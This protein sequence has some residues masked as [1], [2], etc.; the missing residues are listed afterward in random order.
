MLRWFVRY[1]F[2]VWLVVVLAGAITFGHSAP[3]P[4][5]DGFLWLIRPSIMTA[6]ILFLMAFSLDSSKRA[7]AL[8]EPLASLWGCLV[9]VGLMP[10][11][12]WPLAGVQP[13][14]D[15]NWGLFVT[16]VTPCTLA[17]ASVFTRRAGGNDAVSLLTTLITNL[18]CV[19]ITPLW[20]QMYFG[21]SGGFDGW[22]LMQQLGICVLLPT[23]FGQAA[24][25]PLQALVSRYRAWIG[26]CAQVLVL[27]LVAVAATNAGRVLG[28][29][30][31]WPTPLSAIAMAGSCVALHLVAV[32]IGWY[33][34]TALR[35]Q[36]PDVIAAAIAGSQKTLPVGLM[37]VTSPELAQDHLPFITFPL[38]VYHAA[39]L[40]IDAMLAD[41]WAH[42]K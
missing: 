33:G 17:T 32:A 14:Q 19:V 42:Q 24:Q 7:A 38:V 40:L 10:L 11:L 31:V 36:R 18:G 34:G 13:L 27:V 15:F 29:Q 37:I 26:F 16:A 39:Q 6:V 22:L 1:W 20:L 28:G 3:A 9:N 41:R 5:I 25:I 30:P 2:L 23:I 35:L 8:R 21:S 12:A 4:A